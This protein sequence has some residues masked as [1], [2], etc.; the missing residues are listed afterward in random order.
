[1]TSTPPV[2]EPE[3]APGDSLSAPET[4]DAVRG[5]ARESLAAHLDG[6]LLT[7]GDLRTRLDAIEAPARWVH[8][9]RRIDEIFGALGSIR[10]AAL[11]RVEPAEPYADRGLFVVGHARSGTTILA[12]ALNTSDDVCCLMEPYLYRSIE[13][14]GFGAAFNAMHHGFRNPP[15][16]GYWVPECSHA[17]GRTVL[18]TLRGTYRYVGEKLA[19]RQREKDYDPDRFLAFAVEEFA[20]SPFICVVRDPLLVTSSTIDLFEGGRFDAPTIAALVRSQLDVYLLI[21]RLALLVPSCF[22]LEHDRIDH[23]TFD[24]L[25]GHLGIDL[26]RAASVY[27]DGFRK[28]PHRPEVHALLAADPTVGALRD[29]HSGLMALIDPRTLRLRAD[30]YGASRVLCEAI[31]ARLRERAP[32]V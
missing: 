31:S 3:E 20:R 5:S 7:L 18:A 11:A 16:K 2:A 15:I 8:L 27:I 22:V 32:A 14:A 13:Q 1:M 6:L 4:T 28:T 26:G 23:G 9:N 12:D 17:S 24:A 30:G 19:F 10:S 25:G 29:V 21:L